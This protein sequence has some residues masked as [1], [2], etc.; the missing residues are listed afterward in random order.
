L[1][2]NAGFKNKHKGFLQRINKNKLLKGTLK[3]LQLDTKANLEFL[4]LRER[5][6][7]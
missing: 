7:N 2:T 3:A 6:Q 5:K 1:I 4:Y